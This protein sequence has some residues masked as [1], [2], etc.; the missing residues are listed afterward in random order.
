MNKKKGQVWIETVLYTLIGLAIIGVLLALI[1]P[2]IDQKKDELV[3]T[4]AMEILNGIDYNIAE[5]EY[6]GV[7]NSRIVQFSLKKGQLFIN[8]K[9][10]EIRFFMDSKHMFSE[11]G[12]EITIGKIKALTEEKAKKRYNVT[13]AIAYKPVV[14][15][16]INDKDEGKVLQA[17]STPYNIIV[18]NKGRNIDF[19]IS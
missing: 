10:D 12:T 16:T 15:I 2:S 11:P 18:I 17:S 1:K 14:N 19:S 6:R 4:Q 7:G 8:G 9:E 13:L 5:V 3:L